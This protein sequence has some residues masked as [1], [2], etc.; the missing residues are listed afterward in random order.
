MSNERVKKLGAALAAA[1]MVFGPTSATTQTLDVDG[2]VALEQISSLVLAGNVSGAL[3]LIDELQAVG[4][5]EIV[6]NGQPIILTELEAMVVGGLTEGELVFF[7]SLLEVAAGGGVT[8]FG[9]EEPTA[10]AQAET[11]EEEDDDDS[12]TFPVGS[13]G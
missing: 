10:V 7:T 12:D 2:G 3:A 6:I 11:D 1:A 13:A 4:V 5:T 8:T 9:F